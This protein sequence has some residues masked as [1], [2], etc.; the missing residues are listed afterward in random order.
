MKSKRTYGLL[1]RSGLGRSVLG[2]TL[3]SVVFA[4][5]SSGPAP[6]PSP[7]PVVIRSG[8]RLFA[9]PERMAAVD[10]VFKAQQENIEMDPGFWIVTVP[11]DTPAYPWESL[12]ISSDSAT[13]GMENGY[14]DAVRVYQLYAHYR[15]MKELGRID[16]FL[17]GGS[18]MEGF[19]FERAIVERVADAWFLGRAFYQAVAYDPLEQILFA[20]EAGYLDAMLLTARGD[21]FE[22][23]KAA[24]LA[25]NPGALDEY[26]EWFLAT[27]DR[28]PPG[29]GDKG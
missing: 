25:E 24:W 20:N 17:P 11:R 29:M 16:E 21:E 26:R 9:D 2:L 6:L 8:E 3:F 18:E 12:Y 1:S 28:E 23:E 15:L 10:S 27:F 5:C 19:E 7:R 22:E 4:A 14:G 13:F